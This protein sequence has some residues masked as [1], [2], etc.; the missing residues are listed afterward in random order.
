[1]LVAGEAFAVSRHGTLLN[2]ILLNE[3]NKNTR[4]FGAGD[5]I[6]HF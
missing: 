3:N 2:H 4:A 5:I 6:L 1:M